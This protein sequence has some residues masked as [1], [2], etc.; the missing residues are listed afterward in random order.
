[1]YQNQSGQGLSPQAGNIPSQPQTTP[2]SKSLNI[3]EIFS[4]AIDIIKFNPIIIGVSAVAVLIPLLFSGLGKLIAFLFL[5]VSKSA[6]LKYM[7]LLII[8]G[9]SFII[10][11]VILPFLTLLGIQIAED[12]YNKTKSD[13]K[14]AS[15]KAFKKLLYGIVASFIYSISVGIGTILCIVPGVYAAV[16]MMLWPVVIMLEEDSGF[17]IKRSMELIKGNFF[18]ALLLGLLFLGVT[19]LGAVLCVVGVILALPIVWAGLVTFYHLIKIEKEKF[20][21]SAQPI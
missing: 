1:M 4:K 15:Q 19:I 2:E 11:I 10:N 14:N 20:Q 12:G 5:A 9:I 3:G 7:I 18:F 17:G 21:T 8:Q 16:V 6:L 13:I